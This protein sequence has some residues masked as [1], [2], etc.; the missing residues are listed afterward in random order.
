MDSINEGSHGESTKM[1]FQGGYISDFFFSFFLMSNK[2]DHRI[3]MSLGH[4]FLYGGQ[5]EDA[6]SR[7]VH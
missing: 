7:G 3:Q 5:R 1:V 2:I 6:R 4:F